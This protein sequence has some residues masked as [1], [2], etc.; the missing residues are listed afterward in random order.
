M[1]GT[2]RRE[3][4]LASNSVRSS[5]VLWMAR[6]GSRHHRLRIQ[7]LLVI[8]VMRSFNGHA[9]SQTCP[10]KHAFKKNV[11]QTRK[12]NQR[13]QFGSSALPVAYAQE[14]LT[15]RAQAGKL[16][17]SI[18]L[19][20]LLIPEPSNTF[21]QDVPK[22]LNPFETFGVVLLQIGEN[23]LMELPIPVAMFIFRASTT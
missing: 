13:N 9:S 16:S 7:A 5:R 18:K 2:T 3:L 14:T 6:A 4:P 20:E 21:G 19:M 12:A 11:H 1:R 17:S 23:H 10:C 15:L 22:N 8:F